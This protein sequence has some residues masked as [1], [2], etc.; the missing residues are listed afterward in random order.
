MPFDLPQA[1]KRLSQLHGQPLAFRAAL[2]DVAFAAGCPVSEQAV[3]LEHGDAVTLRMASHSADGANGL[4]L[5][6][7]DL[8][9][10][11][12]P[13]TW[14]RALDSLG[15]PTLVQ[16]WAVA[17]HALLD[18]APDQPWQLLYT[19]GPALGVPGYV[20]ERTGTAV[21]LAPCPTQPSHTRPW[22]GVAVTLQR[23]DNIWRL[24]ACDW[25]AAITLPGDDALL[26][27]HDWLRALPGAWTLH[28]LTQTSGGDLTAIVRA[29]QPLLPLPGMTLHEL[30]APPRLTFPVNDAL[31]A[32]PSTWLP[33]PLA[34]KTQHDGLWLA[35]L[36]VP[37]AEDASLPE[38]LGALA[39][40]WQV[41]PVARDAAGQVRVAV[42]EKEA[43]GPA[44]AGMDGALWRLPGAGEAEVALR[45]LKAKLLDA[46]RARQA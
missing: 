32:W 46:F 25:L 9:P 10:P 24:P 27:L 42:S 8:D 35:G 20:R 43:V 33:Q 4:Q 12:G 17:L 5:A 38:Q 18:V 30:T 15:G 40:E 3:A 29:D 16:T 7:L 14:P 13:G 11:G 1:V 19:R 44:A 28:Q 26:R 36:T 37:L 22:D 39:L 41:E 21:Q 2:L 45:G 34:V 31:L 6:V 23:A